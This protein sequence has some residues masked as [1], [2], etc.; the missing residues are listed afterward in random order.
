MDLINK[1]FKSQL[2]A[3]TVGR[4]HNYRNTKSLGQRVIERCLDSWVDKQTSWC[5][6]SASTTSPDL[7]GS[8]R[9]SI[10]ENSLLEEGFSYDVSRVKEVGPDRTAAEWIVRC[11]GKVRFVLPSV[12]QSLDSTK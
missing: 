7:D 11:G 6:R 5:R 2:D 12:V 9:D 3:L 1:D 10:S 8:L 4:P